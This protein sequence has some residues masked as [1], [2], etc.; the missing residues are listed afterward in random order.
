[1]FPVD[2]ILILSIHF[3]II[4]DS[5]NVFFLHSVDSYFIVF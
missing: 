4:S 2:I 5:N 1:M 3:A